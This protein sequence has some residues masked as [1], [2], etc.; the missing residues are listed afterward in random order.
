VRTLTTLL[1]ILVGVALMTALGACSREPD[2]EELRA[3]VQRRLDE[4]FQ[5]GLFQLTSLRRSGSAPFRDPEQGAGLLVYFNA[6]IEFLKDS[7]LASWDSLNLG[8]LLYLLGATEAGVQGYRG[9][10]NTRGDVLRVHGRVLFA[11]RD[12]DWTPLV[13]APPEPLARE[14]VRTLEG[15]GAQAVLSRVRALLEHPPIG[16]G[17]EERIIREELRTADRSIAARLARGA[18][19]ILLATGQPLM[20]FNEV[21]SRFAAFATAH[22][23]VIHATPTRGSL[24]NALLVGNG[25]A[26]FG[27][28]QN[29]VAEALYEGAQAELDR[30]QGLRAVLSLW[31]VALQLIA[32]EGSDVRGLRD[33]A[34]RPIAIGTLGS[35]AHFT[36]RRLASSGG[37]PSGR[38]PRAEQLS[39]ERGIESLETGAVDALL[40]TEPVPMRAVQALASRAGIRLVSLEADVI[41]AVTEEHASYRPYVIP[42]RTYP[43]QTEPVTTLGLSAMLVTTAATPDALV[44]ELLDQVFASIDEVEEAEFHASFISRQT[45]RVG[46]SIPLHPA[47]EAYLNR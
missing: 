33:L 18:G 2:A 20:T 4:D 3:E 40:L 28:V 19:A 1:R 35:G 29:D 44:T 34:G 30:T 12:G 45:A 39:P 5:A 11:Q 15:A 25:D 13:A 23:L 27:F 38:W 8:T 37:I 31:P 43:G 36:A 10:E 22:G 7:E 42:A 17:A 21:G 6:E 24:A 32:L 47:A 41:H 26:E 9:R 16:A 46:V 14:G